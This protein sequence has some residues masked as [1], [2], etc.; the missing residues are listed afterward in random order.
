MSTTEID[1]AMQDLGVD[2]EVVYHGVSENPL[3]PAHSRFD[4]TFRF[5]GREDVFP[6][7]HPDAV[8]GEPDPAVVIDTLFSEAHSLEDYPDFDPDFHGDR[9]TY[10]ALVDVERRLHRLFGE[11]FDVLME[12]DSGSGW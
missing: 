6:F 3:F 4:V 11:K 10:Y 12:A 5:Q 8:G 7:Y 2:S 9:E 1:Q